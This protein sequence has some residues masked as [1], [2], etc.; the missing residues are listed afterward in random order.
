MWVNMCVCVFV[1]PLWVEDFMKIGVHLG[2]NRVIVRIMQVAVM[3]MCSVVPP[4]VN[5]N[6]VLCLCLCVLWS[7]AVTAL[8]WVAALQES[9]ISGDAVDMCNR[10]P[11]LWRPYSSFYVYFS[12]NFRPA[13]ISL[14]T[15]RWRVTG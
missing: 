2:K 13:S 1:C 11:K 5:Q 8:M 4:K 9:Y 12:R 10:W 7:S 14:I 3:V 6:T 15:S